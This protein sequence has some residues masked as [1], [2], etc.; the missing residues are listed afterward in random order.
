MK[1]R[2]ALVLGIAGLMVLGVAAVAF[3]ATFVGNNGPNNITGTANPDAIYGLSGADTLRGA[4]AGDTIEGG[5]GTDTIRGDAGNDVVQGGA[6]A[7]DVFGDA[8][9]DTLYGNFGADFL[10]GG[11]GNDLIDAVDGTTTDVITCGD[12]FDILAYDTNGGEDDFPNDG[13]CERTDGINTEF[14]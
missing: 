2:V 14:P 13:S 10:S 1:R 7:D 8:D 4:G 3:A 6:G 12:G 5:L 11:P 9:N